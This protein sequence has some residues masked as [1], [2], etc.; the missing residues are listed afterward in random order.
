MVIEEK[1]TRELVK[2][3]AK[4]SLDILS[5]F[6]SKRSGKSDN[7]QSDLESGIEVHID[8]ALTFSENISI[9]RGPE[10]KNTLN[11]S[12]QL[13]LAKQDRRFSVHNT[14]KVVNEDDLLI[15]DSHHIILGD[16]GAG[17]TTTLKRLTSKVFD[18]VFQDVTD[19]K[20]SFPIVVRLGE[21]ESS[22]TLF[23]HLCDQLGIEYSCT[24]KIIE[25]KVSKDIYYDDVK[26]VEEEVEDPSIGELIKVKREVT[27]QKHKEIE[28]VKTEKKL[29]YKIGSKP[30]KYAISNYLNELE[31]IVLLDGLDEVHFQIKDQVYKD[32]KEISRNLTTSKIILTSRYIQE[33]PTFKRFNVNEILPLSDEQKHSIAKLWIKNTDVFFSKLKML[34]YSDLTDRPL[35]LYFLLK[36]FDNNNE[37]LPRQAVDVYRQV[38]LLAIREWDEDK[39]L[40]IRRFSKYKA[41]DSYK[42]EDFLSELSFELTYS[43]GVKKVFSHKQLEIAYL[44]IHRRYPDLSEKNAKS[45]I[46]DIEAHNGLVIEI[47]NNKFEFSHLSIQE[48]LCAKYILSTQITRKH[49]ELINIYPAP[50]AIA[51]VL[52]PKP[53]DWF[54]LFWLYQIDE[55]NIHYQINSD[56]LFEYI[57]RLLI[58]KIHFSRPTIELGFAILYLFM[59]YSKTKAVSKLVQFSK[60][61]NIYESVFDA[62]GCFNIEKY[63]GDYYF[64][65]EHEPLSNLNIKYPREGNV[66]IKY[67]RELIE[68]RTG[69]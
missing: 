46:R 15:D 58:E 29:V 40:E 56:K 24:E 57:D 43:L 69:S 34:P 5:D 35:F 32:V 65:I 9:F 54:A 17:K 51:N 23:T 1:L 41:F 27:E 61:P 11:N 59:K 2:I 44:H 42:K 10:N 55:I 50:L 52:T 26:I 28:E 8:K 63:E 21:I 20:Y 13:C 47:Y 38:V 45:V 22:E 53:E 18:F 36:L 37:E 62:K 49:Y 67:L 66:K 31:C 16:P 3:I 68:E 12:I 60:L 6:F 19:Y 30:I 4:K 48:Y 33:V 39:E 25:H 64:D 14:S 7:F